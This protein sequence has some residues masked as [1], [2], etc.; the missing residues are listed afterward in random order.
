MNWQCTSF[1]GNLN[2]RKNC[3]TFYRLD[4]KLSHGYE[5]IHQQG[6]EIDELVR[7]K[8]RSKKN[9]TLVQWY[10]QLLDEMD[11][12]DNLRSM[13]VTR[14]ANKRLRLHQREGQ[15]FVLTK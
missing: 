11:K 5:Q 15:I 13:H 4:E 6:A 1:L 3:L 8:E 7:R 2:G 9:S 14:G 10:L 12:M